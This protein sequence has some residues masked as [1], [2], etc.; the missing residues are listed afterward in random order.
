[1]PSLFKEEV[2]GC[3]VFGVRSNG[4]KESGL[5]MAIST[6]QHRSQH[7]SI[8]LSAS[9]GASEGLRMSPLMSDLSKIN[10]FEQGELV[11]DQ[12]VAKTRQL[13]R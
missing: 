5:R 11:W 6:S 9:K 2:V 3:A 7:R 4:T 13:L 8:P 1:M 12:V 10:I